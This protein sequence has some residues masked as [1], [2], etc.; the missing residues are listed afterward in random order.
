MA[1]KIDNKIIYNADDEE[2]QC[3]K[4]DNFEIPDTFCMNNCGGGHGWNGYQRTEII[5]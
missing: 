4:C 2:P 5:K 3:Q 1:D